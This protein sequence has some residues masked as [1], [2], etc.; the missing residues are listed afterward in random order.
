MHRGIYIN[1]DRQPYRRRWIEAELRHFGL[2]YERLPA[3]DGAALP[4]RPPR[5]AEVGCFLS[6]VAALERARS[7]DGITHIIEDDVALSPHVAP[8]LDFA[9]SS[10]LFERFDLVFLDMWV[11]LN[12]QIVLDLQRVANKAAVESRSGRDYSRFAVVD[13][14]GFRVGS[15]ASYA[16][17][18]RNLE[19]IVAEVKA[20]IGEGKP[21]DACFGRLA[22]QGRI[23]ACM[24]LPFV[25]TIDP[26]QGLDSTIQ[27]IDKGRYDLLLRLRRGFFIDRDLREVLAAIDR[28]RS[29]EPHPMLDRIREGFAGGGW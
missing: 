19:R 5:A 26:V 16:V 4:Q 13:L 3:T 2:E 28:S 11:D 6:H 8:F 10:G 15:S 1:L 23:R 24:I 14:Q 18:P 17:G 22:R 21:I 20:R 12:A 29:A 7:W 27:T 9:H 25:T